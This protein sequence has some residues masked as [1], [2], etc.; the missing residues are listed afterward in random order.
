MT[1]EQQAALD[2]LA[3]ASGASQ[4]ASLRRQAVPEEN[5]SSIRLSSLT[6]SALEELAIAVEEEQFLRSRRRV[7]LMFAE[8]A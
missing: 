2:N 7:A 5:A 8:T 6:D 4:P 1:R 3:Q